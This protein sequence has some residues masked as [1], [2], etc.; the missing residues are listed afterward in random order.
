MNGARRLPPLHRRCKSGDSILELRKEPDGRATR[1]QFEAIRKSAII[2][3]DL[4]TLEES[5]KL[6][7]RARLATPNARNRGHP[8]ECPVKGAVLMISKG[9]PPIAKVS[10]ETLAEM[11][12]TTRFPRE[13][14]HE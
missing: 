8:E 3:A 1:V 5:A 9:K 10:E 6:P 4:E 12:G 14:L 11:I 7:Q 2:H 13:F